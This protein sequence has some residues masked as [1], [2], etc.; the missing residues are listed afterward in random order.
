VYTDATLKARSQLEA[1]TISSGKSG[2][3]LCW[4]LRGQC[5]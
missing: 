5:F 3:H 2:L 1:A 4:Y